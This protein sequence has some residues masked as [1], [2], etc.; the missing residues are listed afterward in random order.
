MDGGKGERFGRG[1]VLSRES[2]SLDVSMVGEDIGNEQR[3]H[4]LV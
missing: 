1:G 2:E 3:I 4:D